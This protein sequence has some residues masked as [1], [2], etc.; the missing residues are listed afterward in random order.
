M[1]DPRVAAVVVAWNRASILHD[2]LDSLGLQTRRLDDVIVIDN[3]SSDATPRLIQAHPAVTDVVTLPEN[4]GGAGGFAA[5]I[6]HA[7][8]RDADLVWIMDDDTVPRLDALENLLDTRGAYRGEPALLACRADWVDGREHPMNRPRSR[9]FLSLK[10]RKAAAEVGARPVRTSSFVAVLIDVRAVREEGLPIAAYF[11]WNDDFEYTGRLLRHRVGLYVPSARVEH[12][13]KVFGNSTADPGPRF[14]NEARNKVWTFTR[15]S[16][17][18]LLDRFAFAGATLVRW[19]EMLVRSP[20]RS[21]AFAYLR[22]GLREGLKAPR[23]TVE[24]LA[25]TP[26]AAEVEQVE[27]EAGRD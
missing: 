2:T 21:T 14:V 1:T 8:H 24:I 18:G 6:A 19:T 7:L 13:T 12:R 11:L 4:L 27:R 17:F 20:D 5:G 16:A 10:S 15:S 3:A 26:V 9:A 22:Q 25:R 23:S